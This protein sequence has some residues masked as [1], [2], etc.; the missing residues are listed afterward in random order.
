MNEIEI[1]RPEDVAKYERAENIYIS[2]YVEFEM[3][4]SVFSSVQNLRLM[5]HKHKGLDKLA[6]L[7]S[8]ILGKINKRK[9]DLVNLTKLREL[10]IIRGNIENIDFVQHMP[11]LKILSLSYLSKLKSLDYLSSVKGRLV[12]LEIES[13]KNIDWNSDLSSLCNLKSLK[14]INSSP[15]SDISFVEKLTKLEVLVITRTNIKDGNISPAKEIKYV[16]ID[17]KKHYNYRY[18]D[19]IRNIEPK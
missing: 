6:L 9:K 12:E 10:T 8:L 7:Q 5:N 1:I 18:N 11:N 2:D 16:S 13:C 4:L 19:K 17:N 14:I 15:L 3:D